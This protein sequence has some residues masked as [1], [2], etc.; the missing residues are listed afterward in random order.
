MKN[1]FNDFILDKSSKVP[2]Y[3]QVYTY[4]LD[5]IKR[6]KLKEGEQIP[7]ELE[8]CEK[9]TV[10]RTTIRE[11]LRELKLS[12]FISRGRG[13]G[14]FITNKNIA[15]SKALQKV[16]SIVDELKEKGVDT[17]TKILEK[18][19]ITPSSRIRGNLNIARDIKVMYIKRLIFAYSEPLY[20]TEAYL[21]NDIFKEINGMKLVNVSFT[22]L[23][24][25]I[26]KI[27]IISKK[28]I[29]E[30]DIPDKE[31]IELLQIGKND[32]KIIHY[33]Q[34]FWKFIH[35]SAERYIYFEEYFNSSKSK[36]VFET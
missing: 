7:N 13:Q 1:I 22:K 14:T 33:L 30:P 29:L 6:N 20:L 32:K 27:N 3:H 19:I 35:N 18:K 16:S 12:G 5:K 21:P 17:K 2:Y 23:V 24:E 4:L 9:F 31:I 34:T 36:F 10:S 28:R 15:E 11:A 26:F 8:L 25:D